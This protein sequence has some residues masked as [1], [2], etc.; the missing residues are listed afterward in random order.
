MVAVVQQLQLPLAIALLQQ[1]LQVAVQQLQPQPGQ[2][3]DCCLE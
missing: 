2:M 3:I 1:P